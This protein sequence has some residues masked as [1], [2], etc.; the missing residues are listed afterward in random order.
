MPSKDCKCPVDLFAEDDPRE[1]VRQSHGAKGEKRAC[2]SALFVRPAIGGPDGE[3]DSLAAF[4]ALTAQP[5][6]QFFRRKL[7][8]ARIEKNKCRNGARALLVERI[9]EG[10][11]RPEDY[12][13]DRRVG[14]GTVHVVRDEGIEV[15]AARPAG[16]RGKGQFHLS[17]AIPKMCQ[18]FPGT[19][20]GGQGSWGNYPERDV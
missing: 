3:D 16:N 15:L 11:T 6:S 10:L 7:S 19:F 4:I 1:L 20:L 5:P 8:A 17:K 9:E 13:F 12:G 2:L 18:W 14:S